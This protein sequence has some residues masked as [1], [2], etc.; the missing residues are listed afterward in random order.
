MRSSVADG[1]KGPAGD[2]SAYL[3]DLREGVAVLRGS[4]LAPTVVGAA[5]V[6][7]AAGAVFATLPAYVDTVG[8]AG[9]YG[10]LA[11]AFAAGNF[12]E[13]LAASVLEDYPFGRV[14]VACFAVSGVLWSRAVLAGPLPVTVTPFA[15]AFVPIGA[16]N[17]LLASLVQSAVPEGVVDR[18]S[19]ALGSASQVATPIGA[20]AGGAL[21]GVLGSAPVVGAGGAFV[22][23][24]AAYRVVVPSPPHAGGRRGVHR[25]RRDRLRAGEP[26]A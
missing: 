14:S 13:A 22:L 18:V 6:N 4:V 15:L 7:V 19:S 10:V 17:V 21:A 9:A 5:F 23:V 20:L 11:A 26:N 1:G 12:T 25:R 24:L 3:A 2:E 8:G 16:V